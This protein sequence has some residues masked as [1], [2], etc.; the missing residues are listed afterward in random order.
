[1]ARI[2]G[3][4]DPKSKKTKV[5]QRR[6]LNTR[7]WAVA[8][9]LSLLVA[10]GCG[11]LNNADAWMVAYAAPIVFL[12]QIVFAYMAR[13]MTGD[14]KRVRLIFKAPTFLFG[15]LALFNL[16]VFLLG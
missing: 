12:A 14:E 15:A 9:L 4:V 10:G 8:S 7:Q 13:R 2:I 5:H 1:M 3:I 6:G 11:A 16:I